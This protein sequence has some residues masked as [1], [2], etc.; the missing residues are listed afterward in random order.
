MV[1]FN[2][3]IS[4]HPCVPS[5]VGGLLSTGLDLELVKGTGLELARQLWGKKKKSQSFVGYF[6]QHYTD[7][8]NV[9]GPAHK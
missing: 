4:V 3:F 9:V 2:S 7:L 6:S 8:K 5:W 1:S